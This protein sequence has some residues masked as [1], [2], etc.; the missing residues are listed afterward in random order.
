MQ[1]L[2][3]D[4]QNL[5]R[6]KED[7]AVEV[8]RWITEVPYD[9]FE[10]LANARKDDRLEEE[11]APQWTDTAF[12]NHWSQVLDD[13]GARNVRTESI[14]WRSTNI[15][16]RVFDETGG[17]EAI[18]FTRVCEHCQLLP[19]EAFPWWESPNHGGRQKNKT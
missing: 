9:A 6:Y 10:G 15:L 18:E 12:G 3:E 19:V 16:R 7:G 8:H 1:G 2:R 17:R 4:V 5:L 14:A 13:E 11:D